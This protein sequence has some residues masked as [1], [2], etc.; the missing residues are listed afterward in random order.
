MYIG[1]ILMILLSGTLGGEYEYNMVR[2]DSND[3]GRY[4]LQ[5]S[6][7]V[8]LEPRS[9]KGKCLTASSEG[10]MIKL[11]NC[12]AS[13][14]TQLWF[15]DES[16]SRLRPKSDLGLCV[17]LASRMKKCKDV[18]QKQSW[19][20]YDRSRKWLRNTYSFLCM[21]PTSS[22]FLSPCEDGDETLMWDVIAASDGDKEDGD[23]DNVKGD[24]D[25]AG[26]VEGKVYQLDFD[27]YGKDCISAASLDLDAK[28]KVGKCKDPAEA[29]KNLWVLN[30]TDKTWRPLFAQHLCVETS[31]IKEGK[32]LRLNECRT[33]KKK[34]QQWKFNFKSGYSPIRPDIR[35]DLCVIFNSNFNMKLADAATR[36]PGA[37][38]E[39]K[40]REVDVDPTDT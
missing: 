31:K 26:G 40:P 29:K 14:K 11:S 5:D 34:K 21:D 28:L 37:G 7:Y 25:K 6:D 23:G 19:D 38:M 36:C 9:K 17:G 4:L 12:D 30:N 27:N 15:V 10:N 35:P 24:Y 20:Y 8:Q 2:D 1:A 13:K 3:G 32:S 39:W 16:E 33:E 18:S 22:N